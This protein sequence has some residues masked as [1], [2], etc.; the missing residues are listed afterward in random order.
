YAAAQGATRIH[1]RVRRA[2]LGQVVDQRTVGDGQDTAPLIGDTAALA[3]SAGIAGPADGLVAAQRAVAD[4]GGCS[5]VQG[6]ERG[7]EGRPPPRP[8]QVAAGCGCRWPPHRPGCPS[9]Y[10]H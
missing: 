5:Y 8:G 4:G 10:C 7:N 2:A 1:T 3:A 9:A 6:G